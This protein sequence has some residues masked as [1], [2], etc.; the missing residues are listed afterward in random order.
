MLKAAEK[1]LT[2][3]INNVLIKGGHSIGKCHDVL[4]ERV[5]SEKGAF[6]TI[7]SE[8]R[9]NKNDVHGTGCT[10]SSSITAN[11]ALGYDLKQ[12]IKNSKEYIT[13]A[14]SNSIKLGSGSLI[15]NH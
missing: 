14:I 15:I 5:D 11:L 10:L 6:Q 3:G 8:E 1:I 12:S 2:M 4:L 9:I 7:F 13:K